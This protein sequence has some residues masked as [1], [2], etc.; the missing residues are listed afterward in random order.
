[1]ALLFGSSQKIVET[2]RN[3]FASSLL[4]LGKQSVIMF[5]EDIKNLNLS[6]YHKKNFNYL[7]NDLKKYLP[8]NSFKKKYIN[9]LFF[10]IL[11][12]SEIKYLDISKYQNADI[13]FNLNKD[14]PPKKITNKFDCILDGS[15]LEHIFS[16]L[17]VLKNINRF[18]KKGGYVIHITALNN[19]SKDGFY[20][21]HPNY[22]KDFYSVNGY[23]IVKNLYWVMDYEKKIFN[24]KAKIK[25]G[26]DYFY[27]N[28]KN[29]DNFSR[30]KN[31]PLQIIFI[32]RKISNKKLTV[33]QQQFYLNKKGWLKNAKI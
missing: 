3:K 20:Q 5:E 24:Q 33:P 30:K 26:R 4:C 28:F 21:F 7:K 13:I 25:R 9:E 12:F 8:K 31:L 27:K 6:E 11:G 14:N 29:A 32:A 23:K 1:M 17:N 22:F 10:L 16:T 19:M 2:F 15:T 18:L